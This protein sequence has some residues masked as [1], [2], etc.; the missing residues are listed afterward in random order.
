[1]C[2]GTNGTAFNNITD[3]WYYYRIWV[4]ERFRELVPARNI[5][6]TQW[7][8]MYL[9]ALGCNIGSNCRFNE[10][11]MAVPHL[12]SIGDGCSIGN[13]AD[14]TNFHVEHNLV[15]VGSIRVNNNVV[16]GSASTICEGVV[17][18]D[19]S[20][21]TAMSTLVTGTTVFSGE[22]FDGIPAQRVGKRNREGETTFKHIGYVRTLCEMLF[23]LLSSTLAGVGFFYIVFPTIILTTK[24]AELW[25]QENNYSWSFEVVWEFFALALPASTIMIFIATILTAI[26]SNF[27]IP[28]P[29]PGIYSISSKEY[30]GQ[31]WNNLVHTNAMNFLFGLFATVFAPLWFR[32]IGTK[33]GKRTE[34]SNVHVGVPGVIEFGSE[35]FAADA[36][37]IGNDDV[38]NNGIT[39]DRVVIGHRTFLGN[40]SYVAGGTILPENVLIGVKSKAPLSEHV[41]PGETWLGN[42]PVLIPRRAETCNSFP[43]HLTFHPPMYRVFFRGVVELIRVILPLTIVVSFAYNILTVIGNLQDIGM[44]VL[45]FLAFGTGFGVIN[46]GIVLV[47]KWLLVQV[48]RPGMHPMWTL[49]VWLSELVTS[50]YYEIGVLN[51]LNCFKGTPFIP[52]LLWLLGCKM[53]WNVYIN[54]TDFTEFDCVTIGGKSC[55][56]CTIFML[57]FPVS[58]PMTR[59][60]DSF[61]QDTF[62]RW[63]TIST[64]PRAINIPPGE[65]LTNRSKQTMQFLTS[66]RVARRISLKTA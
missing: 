60:D 58:V 24:L 55:C 43:T 53:G 25:R 8:S 36:V 51:F 33:V 6:G 42:P 65:T 9:R 49:P 46:Y 28:K 16:I 18:E 12:I 30:Y 37:T 29:T 34:L 56:A 41:K 39:I 38:R 15:Y 57:L 52:S 27:V 23:F 20:E 2:C 64:W 47:F 19:D 17:M 21:L 45:S 61:Y 48:Y 1:M 13:H 10:I 35:S 22:I 50:L 5:V 14:L 26:L 3:G 32:S 40:S 44:V 66:M 59:T 63:A 54:T 62:I 4:A 11:N 7:Y 31:W